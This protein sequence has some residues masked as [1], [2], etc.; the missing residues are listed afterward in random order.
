MSLVRRVK[1]EN[2]KEGGE[3][4]SL[5]DPSEDGDPQAGVVSQHGG[6]EDVLEKGPDGGDKPWW[7]AHA[8]KQAKYIFMVDR[9][10]G[11]FCVDK[12]KESL[13]FFLEM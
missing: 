1:A 2:E 13:L 7:K 12:E 11:F 6:N 8:F 4:A 3:R 5:F 9:V 10:E